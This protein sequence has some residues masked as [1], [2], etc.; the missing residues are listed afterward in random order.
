MIITLL[1]GIVI[2]TLVAAPMGPIGILC[3]RETIQRGRREGLLTGVGATISDTVYGIIS[4]LGIGLV[5]DFIAE[6]DAAL[7][8]VG[9]LLMLA[10]GYYL[11][12]STPTHKL[13]DSKE[14]KIDSMKGVHKV[15]ASFLITL[16][17]PLIVFFFLALYSRFN[18]VKESLHPSLQ[19]ISAILGI[20]VGGLLW[21]FFITYIVNHFREKI[22]M[23][24]IVWINKIVALLFTLIS[25]IGLISGIWMIIF[26]GLS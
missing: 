7:R 19:F 22:S 2:G 12:K 9:S 3:L 24:G 26:P 18:F 15:V 17:N 16:S 10:F 11:Y 21:W 6:N 14:Q 23:N 5:L 4:Y 13:K 25:V 8:I 1:K 20:T